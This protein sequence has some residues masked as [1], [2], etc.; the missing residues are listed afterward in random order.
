[1][2][3]QTQADTDIDSHRHAQTGI[4]GYTDRHGWIQTGRRI[5]RHRWIDR[6]AQ[7]DTQTDKVRPDGY[8]DRQQGDLLNSI[9]FFKIRNVG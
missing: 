8:T 3:T 2:D 1:M 4:D 5:Q 9:S 7:T 6:Q